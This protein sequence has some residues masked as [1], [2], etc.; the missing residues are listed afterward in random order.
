MKAVCLGDE[1]GL[2]RDVTLCS[3][4]GRALGQGPRT[5]SI[6]SL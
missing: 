4:V 2:E 3:M 6:H 5:R 1:R